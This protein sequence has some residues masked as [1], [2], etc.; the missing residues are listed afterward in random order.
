MKALALLLIT[1]ATAS[2]GTLYNVSIDTSSLIGNAAGPFQLD[3]QFID[4]SGTDDGNNTV[5]LGSFNFGGGSY[6]LSATTTGGVSGDPSTSIVLVDSSFFNEYTIGFTPGSTLAF[7]V[8]LTGNVDPGGVPDEF[9]FGI[10]DSSGFEIPALGPGDSLLLADISSASPVLQ[11]YG[12]DV[13][14]NAAGGAPID[15][16]APAITPAASTPEPATLWLL[17]GALLVGMGRRRVRN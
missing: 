6:D 17:A 8:D 14:R 2:A 10:L 13:T 16:S 12:S 3:F 1:A 4:G 11:G 15:L 5:T 9:S 7:S